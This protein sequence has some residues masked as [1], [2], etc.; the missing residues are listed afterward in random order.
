MESLGSGKWNGM[1]ISTKGKS[2]EG[3]E[4]METTWRLNCLVAQCPGS[5]ASCFRHRFADRDRYSVS[6][7]LLLFLH[8]L[9]MCC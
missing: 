8:P 5:M 7:C 1:G 9:H 6:I 2:L 4:L 3:I